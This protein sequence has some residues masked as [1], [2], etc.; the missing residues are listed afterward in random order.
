MHLEDIRNETF[1][2][3]LAGLLNF[4]KGHGYAELSIDNCRRTLAKID[5]F[6]TEHGFAEYHPDIG[7]KFYEDYLS[8]HT[9]I[10]KARAK[11]IG[12][13]VR[14]LN[15]YLSGN[16][17]VNHLKRPPQLLPIPFELT[18]RRYLQDCQE[19]G[20]RVTTLTAKET[21]VRRFLRFCFESGCQDPGQLQLWQIES[22]CLAVKNKDDWAIIRAFLEYLGRADIVVKTLSSIVPHYNRP[23][24][25]PTCYSLEEV[26]S[27]ERA[28]DRS[29]EIGKRDYAMILL[30][31]RYGMRSGDI[32]G[33]TMDDI[34]LCTGTLKFHQQKNGV[35]QVFQ[36]DPE[37][38]GALADYIDNA[39]PHVAEN[40]LFLCMVAPFHPVTTSVLRF[41]TTKYFQKAGVNTAGKRHGPHTFRSSL[42]TSMVN[43]DVP[44]ESVRK[45]LGH[46]DPNAIKH[47]ARVDR[48]R[49]RK[50]AIDV[51]APSGYFA[52]FLKGSDGYE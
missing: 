36:L 29:T 19:K 41:E 44:Y 11:H 5:P 52:E 16:G 51:P 14:R 35:E 28:I 21:K 25:I 2:E 31:S 26:R 13:L 1:R 18:I 33:L 27:V 10:K 17:L 48:E 12:M 7:L 15:D 46:S 45:I 37:V 40:L 43:D 8:E 3:Q 50:Y 42:A 24:P 4:L 22:A 47:Y 6:M 20:N 23:I 30:A 38:R 49:L 32:V 39:R 34:D 9:N